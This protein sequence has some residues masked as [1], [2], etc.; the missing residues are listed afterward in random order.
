LV[1][2]CNT[3]TPQHFIAIKINDDRIHKVIYSELA[4][5]EGAEAFLELIISI[6]TLEW[7]KE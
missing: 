5:F 4:E 7:N 2:A 1:L 3:C 6:S